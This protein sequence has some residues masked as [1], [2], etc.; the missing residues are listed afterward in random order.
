[1]GR[2]KRLKANKLKIRSDKQE[3]NS[4][5]LQTLLITSSHAKVTEG[6]PLR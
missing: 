6:P 2:F 1:M 4:K 3:L 5:E